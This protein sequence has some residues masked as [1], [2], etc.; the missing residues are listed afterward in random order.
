MF[1]SS[2]KPSCPRRSSPCAGPGFEST[3]T[4]TRPR[5]PGAQAEVHVLAAVHKPLVESPEGAPRSR[6]GRGG[7][8][9]GRRVRAGYGRKH[10]GG[11]AGAPPG[12]ARAFPAR[13]MTMP[14][15]SI[16]RVA[17]IQLDIADKPGL[18][19]PARPGRRASG[20]SQPAREHQVVV[21]QGENAAPGDVRRPGLL[22]A[23]KPKIF[24]IQD[25]AVGLASGPRATRGCR[26]CFRRRQG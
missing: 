25:D 23:P 12:R 17:G 7:R 14:A 20:P 26:R 9:R 5:S 13:S 4:F 15:W 1:S 10:P 2:R 6:S 18:G 11:H 19:I 8:P 16:S 22:A 3:T 21:E 24:L